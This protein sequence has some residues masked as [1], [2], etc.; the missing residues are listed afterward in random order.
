MRSVHRYDIDHK[1]RP[2]FFCVYKEIQTYL[3]SIS[4]WTSATISG[5]HPIKILKLLHPDMKQK[6][7]SISKIWNRYES[8]NAPDI[9]PLFLKFKFPG[10]HKKKITYMIHFMMMYW[11]GLFFGGW[12]KS[13]NTKTITLGF[14]FKNSATFLNIYTKIN[15]SWLCA[16]NQLEIQGNQ[17]FA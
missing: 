13:S 16:K 8:R 15:K 6:C 2:P 9:V 1:Y 7:Q 17:T 12:D 3:F 10:R 4:W 5:A 14:F 11:Y